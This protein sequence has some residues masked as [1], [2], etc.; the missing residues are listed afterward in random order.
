MPS[1]SKVKA[2]PRWSKKIREGNL[3]SDPLVRVLDSI[4]HLVADHNQLLLLDLCLFLPN[5]ESMR[6]VLVKEVWLQSVDDLQS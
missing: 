3:T 2:R 6:Y 5:L 4:E 1:L